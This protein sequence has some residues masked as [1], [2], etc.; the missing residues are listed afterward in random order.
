VITKEVD[1]LREQYHLPGMKILQFAF[2]GMDDNPYLPQNIDEDS[3]VY[4]GTHDNDTSLGWYQQLDEQS[5]GHLH[6]VLG[7]QAPKMP[8]A[9]IQL[10]L[11][12][13]ANITII[14]M[15]D[16]LGLDASHRMNIPG[17]MGGNWQWRFDWDTL[18]KEQTDYL[19]QAI[20]QSKRANKWH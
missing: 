4:T 6:A 8:Q 7:N 20:K 2:G 1:A 18:K 17:T 16:I 9:L 3:V 14:P 5:K 11:E 13:K 15:Q 10:A 12:T 19:K